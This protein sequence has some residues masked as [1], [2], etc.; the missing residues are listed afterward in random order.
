MKSCALGLQP[1]VGKQ[2][3]LSFKRNT[4]GDDVCGSTPFCS[5]QK[6]FS[7]SLAVVTLPVCPFVGTGA[8]SAFNGYSVGDNLAALKCASASVDINVRKTNCPPMYLHLK[9]FISLQCS[10]G[11]YPEHGKGNAQAGD[12]RFLLG[13]ALCHMSRLSAISSIPKLGGY[14]FV[15]LSRLLQLCQDIQGCQEF[16]APVFRAEITR[17]EAWCS[18]LQPVLNR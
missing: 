1:K 10:A 2:S 9:M 13:D 5:S 3:N 14:S 11:W 16:V 15:Q 8:F 4:C 12:V 6:A 7:A 18:K 17:H